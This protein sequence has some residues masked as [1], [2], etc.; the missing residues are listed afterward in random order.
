[1]S[2]TQD[3]ERMLE[4]IK[5]IMKKGSE[6]LSKH[7]NI[8]SI[9]T[10]DGGREISPD[11]EREIS[12]F[13]EEVKQDAMKGSRDLPSGNVSSER[14]LPVLIGAVTT[15]YQLYKDNPGAVSAVKSVIKKVWPW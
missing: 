15:G 10:S 1:M 2:T 6:L 8:L 9:F 4:E 12:A 13:A 14:W 7:P 11:Q 5:A 3:D